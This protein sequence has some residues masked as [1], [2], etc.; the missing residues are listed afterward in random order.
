MNGN[1]NHRSGGSTSFNGVQ[2]SGYGDCWGLAQW[3]ATVL[4]YNN[5]ETRIVQG[6]NSYSSNHRW[7]QVK[8]NNNWRNFESS[9]V[10]KRYGSKPYN[11]VCA[12]KRSVVVSY[13]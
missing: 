6:P 9:L 5:Y 2:K 10:T 13:N 4:R 12:S 3:A 1:L 7:V 11:R 8:V